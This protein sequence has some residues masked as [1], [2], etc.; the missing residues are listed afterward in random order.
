MLEQLQVTNLALTERAS[1]SFSPGMSCITGETG[2]GKS[3][4]VDALSLI[5]GA[6]T[7]T[8]MI[9]EGSDRLEVEASFS[10]DGEACREYLQS[11][12]LGDEDGGQVII[13]RTVSRDGKSRAQVN[14]HSVNLSVLRDLGEYLLSIH[15]QH[16]SIKLIEQDNQLLLLDAFGALTEERGELA[17]AFNLYNTARGELTAMG[18]EQKELARD[19]KTLR[20]QQEILDELGL[21][22]GDYESLEADFDRAMNQSKI[23]QALSD[24]MSALD[25]DAG[26]AIAL[27]QGRIEALRAVVKYEEGVKDAIAPLEEALSRLQEGR[28]AVSGLISSQDTAD[29]S[30]VEQRMSRCHE[31]ARQLKVQPKDLYLKKDE[32]D[33]QISHFLSLKDSIEAKTGEVKELRERYER[34]AKALSAKRAKAAGRMSKS[35][36]ELIRTL[37]MPDGQFRAELEY[38]ETIRPRVTGRDNV[39][40]L[41]SANLGQDLKEIGAVA[42]GGELSRL[43]LA[44]EAITSERHSIPT[45]IFDEVDTGISG[46]TA[47]SVGQLLHGLARSVQV[48]TVTHLP[49]VAA[50]ADHHFLVSKS[51][52]ESSTRSDIRLLDKDGRV[53]E[54]ARLMGGKVVTD[55]TLRSAAELLDRAVD[56]A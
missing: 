14:S 11:L 36:T 30:Q 56:N 10:V 52:D 41:F 16:A 18:D 48:L 31:L 24:A 2:A 32:I 40:F 17:K 47:S 27:L 29:P 28:D 39:R 22:E 8:Q 26:G 7:D 3:L 34:L 19:Y 6:R 13:R 1:I 43:A 5:L 4:L 49:Q 44:I 46:R 35:V 53:E 12:D 54:I 9:K 51:N 33:G 20:R 37:A 21:K 15:G 23:S 55:A 42:S 50:F 38:D 45:I 25:S